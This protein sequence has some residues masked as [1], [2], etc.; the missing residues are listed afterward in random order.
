MGK[1]FENFDVEFE[2]KP[3]DMKRLLKIY[4]GLKKYKKSSF[5]AI[6]KLEGKET[7]IDKLIK[8]SEEE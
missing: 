7:I 3:D 1:G 6:E 8:E 2:V 5:Y 4:K